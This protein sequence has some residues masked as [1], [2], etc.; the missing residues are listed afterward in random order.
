MFSK[1]LIANRGEVAVRIIR[2]CREMGIKTVAVYSTADAYALHTAMADQAVCIGEASSADSYLNAERI[3]SAAL[4]TGAQAIHP[5][6]GF[7][8]ENQDFARMCEKYG[9]VFIG[10]SA[11]I[12]DK[13]SDKEL[14]KRMM[15]Q[16]G[17]PVIPGSQ[18]VTDVEQARKCADEIGYPVLLKAV[19]GGGGRGIRQVGRAEE[20]ENAYNTACAESLAAFGSGDLY[21]EKLIEPAR[22]IEFQILADEAGNVVCLGE[23]ECSIQKNH[24]KLV[25][26]TPSPAVT[27]DMR[28]KLIP[29][30]LDAIRQ[31]GYTNAGTLEFLVDRDGNFYFMEM[32]VRLQ[33]EHTITEQ[34]TGVDI[35]KWQIRIA[36]GVELDFTQDQVK[37]NGVSIECRINARTSGRVDF[38]NIPG[39]PF[40]R[41]DT[42]LWNG[43]TV[44]PFYDSLIGKLVVWA[45]TREEAIRKM[46]AAL[47]E[48]TIRGLP[49]NT[50]EDLAIVSSESFADGQYDTN[51][52]EHIDRQIL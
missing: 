36:A 52:F 45:S 38:L 11:D 43:I 9:I 31:I 6:Y 49:T 28:Q 48:L 1:I 21:V 14:A 23:R 30:V 33:V 35:V 5:G 19:S 13:L 4:A 8:S 22:H 39:G 42:F 51:Y 7:L 34:V 40:V 41:F 44:T 17:V 24:Q 10:P 32:N 29:K 27:E 25:E 15:A 18:A 47:C 37:F 16:A 2:A 3:I 20:L 12:M 26:E 46:K 50:D